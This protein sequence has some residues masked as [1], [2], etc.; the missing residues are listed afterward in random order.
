MFLFFTFFS[1][2]ACATDFDEDEMPDEWERKNGLRVDKVDAHEDADND[3]L[4]N[5]QEYQYT[6]D[7]Q[8]PDTDDDGTSDKDEIEKRADPLNPLAPS[9][10]NASFLLNTAIILLLVAA[11]T[12]SCLVFI[13]HRDEKSNAVSSLHNETANKRGTSEEKYVFAIPDLTDTKPKLMSVNRYSK[14][15]NQKLDLRK[16]IFSEFSIVEPSKE[17]E[18]NAIPQSQANQDT[19]EGNSAI[20]KLTGVVNKDKS[21]LDKLKGLV[22][23]KQ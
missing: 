2:L 1:L 4:T 16:R 7:P 18:E 15:E 21:A 14:I 12:V 9:L 20:E 22:K 5:A 11:V 8:S 19:F 13:T 3:G 23:R 6:T 17:K 10:L